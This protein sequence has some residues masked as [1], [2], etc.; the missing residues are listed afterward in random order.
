MSAEPLARAAVL[1]LAGG[2]RSQV[3]W[4]AMAIR[5][6]GF[7]RPG[8]LI[9]IGAFAGELIADKS[10]RMPSRLRARGLAF[11][12]AGSGSVGFALAGPRGAAV[13]AS[14]AMASA[15]VMSR[16]R[17]ALGERTGIPDPVLAAIEDGLALG[18]ALW[19][20]AGGG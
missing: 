1:G 10:P 20:T 3:P 6:R 7:R 12:L 14:T 4:A 9:P 17:V 19:A 18:L 2:M 11:R 8:G 13:A 15:Q 16:G 5:D